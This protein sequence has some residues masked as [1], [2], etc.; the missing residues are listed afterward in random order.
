MISVGV[1]FTQQFF[2]PRQ[3]SDDGTLSLSVRYEYNSLN[4]LFGTVNQVNVAKNE[5]TYKPNWFNNAIPY[6]GQDI[7]TYFTDSINSSSS[8]INDS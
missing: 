4:S 3:Y 5:I 7:V 1:Q 2:D 6:F 8:V